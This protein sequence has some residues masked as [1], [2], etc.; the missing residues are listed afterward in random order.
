M[1]CYLILKVSMEQTKNIN[2][3]WASNKSPNP[4]VVYKCRYVD[5]DVAIFHVCMLV[6]GTKECP[7]YILGIRNCKIQTC[8]VCSMFDE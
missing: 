7:K 2:T 5:V 1:A 4:C 6:L 3:K 8:D